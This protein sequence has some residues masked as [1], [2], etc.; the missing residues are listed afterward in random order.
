MEMVEVNHVV[1]NKLRPRDE[2]AHQ[3]RIVRYFNSKRIFN[4]PNRRQSVHGCTN[5]ADTLR[6]Y[7]RL[8]RIAIPQ[9]QFNATEHRART[10]GIRDLMSIHLRLDAEVALNSGNGINHN[11][12]HGY[13]SST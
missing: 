12:R 8:P 10:P 13:F 6:P 7:P 2:I 9:N 11:T 1:L 3:P 4:G 5:A